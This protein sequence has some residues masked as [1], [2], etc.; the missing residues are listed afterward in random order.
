MCIKKFFIGTSDVPSSR[1]IIRHEDISFD[2]NTETITIKNVR[3]I[4]LV[5]P[6]SKSMDPI[7]DIGHTNIFS[8]SPEYL[9]ITKLGIGDLILHEQLV[10]T[11]GGIMRKAWINH[12]IVKIG[13]D[14][15]G[16]YC[17]TK[18]LN[19]L[20]ADKWKIREEDLRGITIGVIW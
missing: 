20:S 18:G 11:A 12:F 17:R 7:M 19:N 14:K 13:S 5:R 16:W 8:T 3:G 2:E 9:D 10:R 1:D 15:D 6:T 4:R